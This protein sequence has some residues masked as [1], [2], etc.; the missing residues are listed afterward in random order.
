M[1]FVQMLKRIPVALTDEVIRL[2]AEQH[3]KVLKEEYQP[4][5]EDRKAIL[6][7]M[8]LIAKHEKKVLKIMIDFY[9]RHRGTD[10]RLLETIASVLIQ[11]AGVEDES[12]KA[13]IKEK[14]SRTLKKL[15]ASR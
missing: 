5:E 14:K 8:K 4:S 10:E 2:K 1:T 3:Q 15:K 7:A 9:R 12:R 6:E 11:L 13:L